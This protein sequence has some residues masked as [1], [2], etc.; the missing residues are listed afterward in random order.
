MKSSFIFIIILAFACQKSS[1]ELPIL[2]YKIDASGNKINYTISYNDFTNQLGHPFSTNNI[3]N[4]VFIANFFF[5]NCPSICP[6]MRKEL[7]AVAET[8]NNEDDF[9]IV[10]HTIDPE[11]D[12]VEVLKS[13]SEV[14]GISSKKWQFIRSSSENTRNQ[15]NLF[16]TNFKPNE[17]G[18][19]F[20]HSSYVA[21]IDKKQQIR[22]IY[23][24]LVSEEVE[25]MKNDIKLLLK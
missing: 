5:T 3:N 10:S 25:R 8:F 21:L 1:K 11:N 14:T 4:K 18:T 2:S 20:Y 15:A 19:D 22:G 24:T 16:M 13:Y 9:L 6:P 12:S 17:A 7:M 23:N